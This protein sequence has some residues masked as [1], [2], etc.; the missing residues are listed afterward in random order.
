M[1][2]LVVWVNMRVFLVPCS[3]WCDTVIARIVY[4]LGRGMKA[5]G[6]AAASIQVAWRPWNMSAADK[7]SPSTGCMG[8][9]GGH[10]SYLDPAHS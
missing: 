7:R 8:A 2:D 9:P 4:A 5:V 10:M 6:E 1:V 3:R